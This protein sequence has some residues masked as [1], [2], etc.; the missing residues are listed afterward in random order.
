MIIDLSGG[1]IAAIGTGIV[2][3]GGAVSA[4]IRHLYVGREKE[5]D[6][7]LED[8]RAHTA[9]LLDFQ[10]RLRAEDEREKAELQAKLDAA[11]APRSSPGRRKARP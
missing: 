4:I 10:R 8:A 11:L 6:A 5:R 9:E 3:I 7:R 1:E 2:S